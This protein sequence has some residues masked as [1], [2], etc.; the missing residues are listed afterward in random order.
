MYVKDDLLNLVATLRA[1]P[2]N[3]ECPGGERGFLLNLP[4][5]QFPSYDRHIAANLN[6]LYL[7]DGYLNGHPKYKK[8]EPLEL[9]DGSAVAQPFKN[10]T[11]SGKTFH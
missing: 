5:A 7:Q 8:N 10:N 11:K 3:V 1:A 9:I 4:E 6:G 2:V